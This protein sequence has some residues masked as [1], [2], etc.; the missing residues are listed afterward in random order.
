MVSGICYSDLHLTPANLTKIG[1]A[2][3]PQGTGYFLLKGTDAGTFDIRGTS[4][5]KISIFLELD[6]R[7]RRVLLKHA[8]RQITTQNSC[9]LK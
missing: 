3:P 5:F 9:S 1:K 2:N 4:N 8:H 7:A 6:S